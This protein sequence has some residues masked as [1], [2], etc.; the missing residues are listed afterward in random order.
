LVVAAA[1]AEADDEVHRLA[2]VEIGDALRA[3]RGALQ[4]QRRAGEQRQYE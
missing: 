2:A 3:G 1:G 4:H